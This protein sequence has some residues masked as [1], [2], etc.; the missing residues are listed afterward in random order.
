M[1]IDEL[2]EK[3]KQ[4][5]SP[6]GYKEG[7]LKHYVFSD[8]MEFGF[9]MQELHPVDGRQ[10]RAEEFCKYIVSI[11][12]SFPELYREYKVM[13]RMIECLAGLVENESNEKAEDVIQR[14]RISAESELKEVSGDGK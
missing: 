4:F 7:T 2:M 10:V 13:E 3:A 6:L 12:N 5:T 11:F 1:K 14:Y 8:D 9:A